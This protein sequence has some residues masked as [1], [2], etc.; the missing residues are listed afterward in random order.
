MVNGA[1]RDKDSISA[2][3]GGN[4]FTGTWLRAN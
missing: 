2:L 4:S 1:G 3:S